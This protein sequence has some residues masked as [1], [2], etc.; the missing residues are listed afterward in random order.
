MSN[1]GGADGLFSWTNSNDE[2]TT[3][4]VMSVSRSRVLYATNKSA[5]HVEAVQRLAV[6]HGA[7]A[8]IKRLPRVAGVPIKDIREV[9]W[10]PVG[11]R[12]VISTASAASATSRGSRREIDFVIPNR[13]A[14]NGMFR[15]ISG[16]ANGD[17]SREGLGIIDSLKTPASA[18]G[19]A[20]VV[21]AVLY[22]ALMAE[23]S[24]YEPSGR[25]TGWIRLIMSIAGMLGHI[26]ILGIFGGIAA[27]SLLV[28]GARILNRPQVQV[29]TVA[30]AKATRTR[31]PA[32][33]GR[34]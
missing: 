31:T 6:E 21:G 3:A 34:I 13:S 11:G 20:I 12:F 24:G 16:Y 7:E 17:V 19:L 28:I 15:A 25:R 30:G 9:R 29:L 22:G 8:A 23:Q 1:N 27:L 4:S 26:G 14:G 18:L 5:E 2:V 32:A 33:V 10:S